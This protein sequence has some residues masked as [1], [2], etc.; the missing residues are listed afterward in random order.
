MWPV[1]I[2]YLATCMGKFLSV[3]APPTPHSQLSCTW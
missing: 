3:S 2:D 1:Y